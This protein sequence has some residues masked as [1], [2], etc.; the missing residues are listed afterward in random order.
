METVRNAL[1]RG[2][3]SHLY[4]PHTT[5]S[6]RPARSGSQPS[7]W[8]ASRTVIAPTLAAASAIASRSA[9]SPVLICTALNATAS[10]PESI[11]STS[12]EGRTVRTSRRS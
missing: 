7:A 4:A 2:D 6:K 3:I 8:V 9:T 10:T 11:A 5:A 1:P 12:C